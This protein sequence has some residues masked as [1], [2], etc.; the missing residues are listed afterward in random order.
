MAKKYIAIA[1]NMGSGKSSLVDFLCRE[2]GFKPFFEPNDINPYL[3]DFYKDMKKWA[4]HSQL[5]F[6]THKFRIHQ[7]LDRSKEI[8]VQDR[9]IHEDAE[10]F[11]TNL[12][13]S[14]FLHKRDYNTYM[15]LYRTIL[16]SIQPPDVMIYLECPL[17]TLKKRISKRGRQIEKGV[18]DKYL[19]GLEKLYK[20]W[21]DK[22]DLSPLIRISTE[23]Y[24]YMDDFIIRQQI[25]MELEK[26]V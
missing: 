17:R 24:D 4:Y 1:G 13:K 2:Y 7:E 8:V 25:T 16:G 19:Q 6:L 10:I 22:Y 14:G 20:R 21:I 11:C 26:C 3:A 18:P 9:T 15:S 23:K 5:H 12:Y